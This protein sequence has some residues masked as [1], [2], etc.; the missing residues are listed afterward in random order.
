MATYTA[1]KAQSTVQPRFLHEGMVHEIATYSA[2]ITFAVADVVQMVKVPDGAV[3]HDLWVQSDSVEAGTGDVV[4]AV[5]DGDDANRYI[6]AAIGS[7]TTIIRPTYRMGYEYS[8]NDTIDITYVT[9]P[10]S[11]ETAS[12]VFTL[13]V[14]Y[15]CDKLGVS[16]G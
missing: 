12:A 9:A 13:S 7:A 11:P 3:I 8:A 16:G 2:S 10:T 15:S 1:D 5:G 6:S 14:V 4:L